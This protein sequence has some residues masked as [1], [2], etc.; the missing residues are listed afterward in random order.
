MLQHTL[1]VNSVPLAPGPQSRDILETQEFF[2][3][4]METVAALKPADKASNYTDS[5]LRRLRS[6]CSLIEAKLM[7]SLLIFHNN[8]LL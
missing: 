8:L 6:A 2:N 4:F 3:N 5:D 7:T 1:F